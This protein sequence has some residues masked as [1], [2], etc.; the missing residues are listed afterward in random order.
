VK[1]VVI[2]NV[3]IKIHDVNSLP[4]WK[5][6]IQWELFFATGVTTSGAE[7]LSPFT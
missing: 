6:A 2:A 5:I 7:A 4:K 3:L 1:N